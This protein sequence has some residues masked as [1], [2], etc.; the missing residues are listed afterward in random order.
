VSKRPIAVNILILLWLLLA[1]IF[2]SL[3]LYSANNSINIPDWNLHPTVSSMLFFGTL[4]VTIVWLVFAILFIIFAYG[5]L[6][7]FVW[8][9]TTGL[10]ISTIFLVVFSLMLVSLMVTALVVP[11]S[12]ATEALII[13]I[14]SIFT[15]LGI[16]YHLTRPKTR[17]YFDVVKK[18]KNSDKRL[19][20]EIYFS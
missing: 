17:L 8:V 2:I 4:L 14:I 9:W 13:T 6:K 20:H 1:L 19:D 16:I 10:I 12:F 5:V 15:D 3:G 18:P 7:K 11:T